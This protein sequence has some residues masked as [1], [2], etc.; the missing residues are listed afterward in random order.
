MKIGL[1][2]D[3][4]VPL[5][6][7]LGIGASRVAAVRAGRI[8]LSEHESMTGFKPGGHTLSTHVGKSDAELLARFEANKRLQYSTTFTN[9]RIAEKAI[10]R[11][12]FANRR[13]IKSVSGGGG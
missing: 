10:S 12:L 6:F 1:T 4:A 8:K 13:V 5:G 3:I 9:V 7:A 11:A 2:V